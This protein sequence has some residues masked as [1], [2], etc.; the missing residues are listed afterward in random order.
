MTT[1]TTQT[2][3]RVPAQAAVTTPRTWKAREIKRLCQLPVDY[4]DPAPLRVEACITKLEIQVKH[5]AENEDVIVT[6]EE[7]EVLKDIQ[8]CE[9]RA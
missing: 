9:G 5:L 7:D 6:G 8:R 3:E 2:S 4:D 1:V